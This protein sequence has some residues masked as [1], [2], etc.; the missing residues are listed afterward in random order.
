[1][2]NSV[3]EPN[4]SRDSIHRTFTVIKD[5]NYGYCNDPKFLDIQFR[6]YRSGQKTLFPILS[7]SF[8][9]ITLW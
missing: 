3:E 6:T 9:G 1:M 4:C 7:S 2:V 5:G 8:G